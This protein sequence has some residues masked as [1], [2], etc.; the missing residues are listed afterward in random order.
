MTGTTPSRDILVC[1]SVTR[2]GQDVRGRVAIA[3][4]HGGVFAVHLALQE[5]VAGLVV[6]DAGHG[7]VAAVQFAVPL[8]H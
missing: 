6:C 2:M 7:R 5:G 8:V 1:D 4:S 3:A